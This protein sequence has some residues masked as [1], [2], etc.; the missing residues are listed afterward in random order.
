MAGTSGT[1][2]GT[3]VKVAVSVSILAASLVISSVI[4]A[5]KQ[6]AAV[7]LPASASAV[8]VRPARTPP[9]VATPV[10]STKPADKPPEKPAIPPYAEPAGAS[11]PL[12]ED[13]LSASVCP[14]G[15]GD[16][17]F[18]EGRTCADPKRRC[19]EPD[20]AHPGECLRFAPSHCRRG[21]AL[22]FCVDRAEYP[23]V[24]G[25][26]PAVMVTYGQAEDAC[27]AE[28]KRLCT[29]TEWT[30]ACEGPVALSF[31]Y[32]DELVP[33]ACNVGR[34]EPKV[35]PEELWEPRNVAGV[36]E[37]VDA[38]VPSET[39]PGCVSPFGV[40]DL[41]GNVEEW[42]KS[43]T[44]FDGA[45]RGGGYVSSPTCRTVRQMRTAGFRQFHTG[46]R[47]CADPVTRAPAHALPRRERPGLVA[48][49]ARFD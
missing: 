47:C 40:K 13:P 39:L 6:R 38:R 9:K 5:H 8:A 21:L 48:P 26:A 34:P 17:L 12:A 1:L 15:H 29:E 45:L 20:P 7:L 35:A 10:A 32:G 11:P 30:F 27:E 25:M 44:G 42:V 16:M 37:R 3:L 22:R 33:G 4:V 18:V 46:F 31:S 49:H 41:V 28:T 43:D 2:R 24:A 19:E 36:V 23:N 14:L